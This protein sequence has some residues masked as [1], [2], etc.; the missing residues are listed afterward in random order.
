MEKNLQQ[1]EAL[2]KFKK[3]VEEVRIC[4]FIT[5]VRGGEG[6]EH[7]RPMANVAVDED[8]TLWF[9]TDIRSIKV[10]EVATDREVHLTFAHPGKESY[11]DLW[12]TGSIVTDRATIKE[13][14]S[15]V[16]KAYFPNG[17]DDPNLALLKV[18][19]S[20][21]YYWESET[22]KMMQFIK[23]AAAAVTKNPAV[24]KSAEGKLDI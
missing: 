18:R 6:H 11:L 5:N 19:P 15:P 4:M 21:V 16:V 14:W 23:Q 9:Y 22:G 7:T 2:Q 24:A 10:E 8:G 3:I 20:D 12:G 13:K 1:D 17:A